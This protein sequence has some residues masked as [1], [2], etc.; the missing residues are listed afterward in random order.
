[1][2]KPA[3]LKSDGAGLTGA[4]EG[5]GVSAGRLGV[6]VA[7]VT[8]AA[9]TSVAV[10]MAAGAVGLGAGRCWQAASVTISARGNKRK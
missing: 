9:G 4:G 8:V 10:D 1:M 5:E 3:G 6:S 7:G 2:R